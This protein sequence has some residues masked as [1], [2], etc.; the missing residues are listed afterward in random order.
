MALNDLKNQNNRNY[1]RMDIHAEIKCRIVETKEEFTGQCK[2]LSHT[3]IKF[4]TSKNLAAGTNVNISVNVN[5]SNIQP[6]VGILTVLRSEK[7]ENN[8]YSISGE[9]KDVH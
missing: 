8:K 9:L 3:G 5:G 7:L 4:E 1:I 2:D 6:L